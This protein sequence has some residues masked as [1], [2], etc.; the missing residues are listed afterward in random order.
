MSNKVQL[1]FVTVGVTVTLSAYAFFESFRVAPGQMFR[2]G[3]QMFM[4][5]TPAP[6][7]QPCT[8]ICK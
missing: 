3:S 8:C 5:T 2:A 7:Q 1:L 4:P 6:P